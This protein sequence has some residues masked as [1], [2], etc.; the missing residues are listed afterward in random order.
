MGSLIVVAVSFAMLRSR[1]ADT[2]KVL[3]TRV[4]T[5]PAVRAASSRSGRDMLVTGAPALTSCS[6]LLEAPTSPSQGKASSALLTID[7]TRA[8]ADE[9]IERNDSIIIAYRASPCP[10][11]RT[12]KKTPLAADIAPSV[13]PIIFRG[14]K[15]LTFANS[16]QES[17]LRLA[18]EGISV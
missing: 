7:L 12:Q 18:A 13:D 1:R 10:C 17:L 3:L 5:T 9:A 16:Q 2:P 4:S 14:L 6:V 11:P 8:V 15:S